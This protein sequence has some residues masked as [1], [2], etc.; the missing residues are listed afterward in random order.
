MMGRKD[1]VTTGRPDGLSA[2]AGELFPWI[3]F[4]PRVHKDGEAGVVGE[5]GWSRGSVVE[6]HLPDTGLAQM[7]LRFVNNRTSGASLNCARS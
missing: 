1:S 7:L 2:V 5:R 4:A 6:V 3:G